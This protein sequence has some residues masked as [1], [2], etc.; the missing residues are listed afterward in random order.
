MGFALLASVCLH[1]SCFRQDCGRFYDLSEPNRRAEF[2]SYD[3]EKQVDV[4]LC[5]LAIE[6]PDYAA[7]EYM[8]EEADAVIPV[9]LKRLKKE[10]NDFHKS[11]IVR[12]FF[13]MAVEG[14]LRGR[15]DIVDQLT[16]EVQ[17]IKDVDWR[18]ACQEELEYIEERV[19]KL[20]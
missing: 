5:G 2:L 12:V 9:L 10:T 1:T 8:T 11:A 4:Y 7:S 15:Q 19:A 13:L 3:P 14:E 20:R 6:P 17:A 16:P 18:A